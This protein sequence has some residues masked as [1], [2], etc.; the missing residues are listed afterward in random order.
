MYI[1]TGM[2]AFLFVV[3]TVFFSLEIDRLIAK[4]D[5]LTRN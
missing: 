3:I 5:D 4:Y 1:L 2:V